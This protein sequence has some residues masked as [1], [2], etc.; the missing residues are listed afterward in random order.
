MQEAAQTLF[1][2]MI[3]APSC[4]GEFLKNMEIYKNS[5]A[6]AVASEDMP[7][8]NRV[9]LAKVSDELISIQGVELGVTIGYI[10]ENEIGLSARRLVAINSQIIMEKMTML[11]IM[12]INK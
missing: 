5:V 4:K 2:L 9:D 6:I 3:T 7:I 11:I 12:I 10:G 1:S 8:L